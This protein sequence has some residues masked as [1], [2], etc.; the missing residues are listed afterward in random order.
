M[1]IFGSV[2]MRL[3]PIDE[4]TYR[5]EVLDSVINE[6]RAAY[7]AGLMLKDCPPYKD[8]QMTDRWR[9]GW[10]YARSDAKKARRR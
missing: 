6:G 4:Q 8:D 1:Q 10:R 5:D 7:R 2:P 9:L 3:H